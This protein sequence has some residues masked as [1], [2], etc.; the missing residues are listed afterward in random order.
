[1]ATLRLTEDVTYTPRD[2]GEGLPHPASFTVIFPGL[3]SEDYLRQHL[4]DAWV[5]AAKI[6]GVLVAVRR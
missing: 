3:V 6:S 5:D 2:D 4:G 1:M